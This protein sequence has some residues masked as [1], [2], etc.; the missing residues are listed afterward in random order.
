MEKAPGVYL[1]GK[2]WWIKYYDQYG[3]RHYERVGPSYRRAVRAR[4]ARLAEIE[5][6]RFGLR[7]RRV[8]TLREFVEGP[9]ENEVTIGLRPST[10]RSYRAYLK[11]HILPAFGDHPLAAITRAS[12]KA[13][14][15]RKAKEQRQGKSRRNPKADQPLLSRKTLVNMVALLDAIMSTAVR[16]YELLPANPLQGILHRKNFPEKLQ[17]DEVRILEPEDFRQAVEHLRPLAWRAVIIA[18]LCGLRWS[19]QA[20]LR[21]EDVDLRR[22]KLHI[23]RGMYKRTSHLPKTRKGTRRVDMSPTVRRILQ[24]VLYQ[25]GYVFSRD[26][27]VTPMGDGTWLKAQWQQTQIKAGIKNVI[28]WHDLRHM[29][30]SLLIAAGKSPKYIAEQAGH[31]SAG[32]TLDRYGHLFETISPTPVE[33]HEELIW[34]SGSPSP[35]PHNV[36]VVSS[37]RQVKAGERQGPKNPTTSGSPSK[38]SKTEK[39]ED[40][41]LANRRA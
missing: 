20:G 12:I 17:D 33:W 39:E 4:S 31:A 18:T 16:D 11:Y 21:I 13:F 2:T 1:R 3:R 34:P 32:F 28:R 10:L 7:R 19:E 22:N 38:Q 35:C 30:V 14:I 37:G 41:R 36:P 26:G 6:G 23:R 27:G 29:F 25:E 15:A 24:A 9:W 5:A 40:R 8:P